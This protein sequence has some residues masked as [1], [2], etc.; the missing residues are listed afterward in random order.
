VVPSQVSRLARV[1][2]PASKES[3]SI[4]WGVRC[5][6]GGGRVAR[7]S[8][9]GIS[10]EQSSC[11]ALTI[12][13]RSRYC[14]HAVD[15][16]GE[17]EM[18]FCIACGALLAD[19]T[20]FCG[21]C[22]APHAG[23]E[24]PFASSGVPP[25]AHNQGPNYEQYERYLLR[26]IADYERISGIIWIVLGVIQICTVV[27]VIAG[28]WNI[29]VGRSRLKGASAIKARHIS[30]PLLYGDI[31]R[32]VVTA[33][34]NFFLGGVVGL[35]LVGFDFYIRDEILANARLFNNSED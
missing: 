26:R 1:W 31:S 24:R 15:S 2:R 32:L 25:H 35:V 6:R 7:R 27:W 14:G 34:I 8:S 4:R 10:R 21:R 11:I 18:P 3:L 16:T 20:A 13:Y 30:V 5:W 9:K 12:R 33:L 17:S 19:G 29:F 23:T 28:V 22:G